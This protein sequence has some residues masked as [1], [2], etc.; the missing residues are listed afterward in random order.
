LAGEFPA[1]GFPQALSFDGVTVDITSGS[2]QA[3]DSYYIR[4]TAL[5]A[6]DIDLNLQRPQQLAL[7][8][9]VST[10]SSLANIG[11]GK[12]S[13]GSIISLYDANDN[14]LPAFATPGQLSPPLLIRFTNP[15][16]Y[17]IYDNTN[18]ASPTL[19]S[20]GIGFTPGQPNKIFADV[21]GVNYTGYQ[22]SLSGFPIAGDEFTVSFNTKGISDNRN[23]VAL[24]ASRLAGI[25]DNG[26][27][28]FEN[29]YGRLIE[30]IGSRTAQVGTSLE[31]SESLF[32]QS[33][34]VRDSISGVNL[35]EEAANLIRFEQ[36][37][38]ASAQVINV[39]RQVFD[40]LLA[41]FR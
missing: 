2:F 32:L 17:N 1:A 30:E 18:P 35:D 22:M 15:T 33:T 40:T 34:A 10:K 19:V 41:A 9:P 28:N 36:A 31:A 26:A 39:A 7:A 13:A 4:P 6:R 20:A 11:N 25:L 8:Q 16:T 27:A 23:A 37:Y 3:G 38:N 14:L 5:G 24:G 29:A 12:I 21:P